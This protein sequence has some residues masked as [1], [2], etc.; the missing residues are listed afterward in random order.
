ML[1]PKP[2]VLGDIML[3]IHASMILPEMVQ[4][5]PLP[6]LS[7]ANWT[8]RDAFGGF[9]EIIAGVGMGTLLHVGSVLGTP[10][11]LR[12]PS[13]WVVREGAVDVAVPCSV[14]ELEFVEF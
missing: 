4:N 10:V 7:V 14:M 11:D 5:L 8:L 3:A 1:F 12:L 9:V 6:D 2:V 13:V